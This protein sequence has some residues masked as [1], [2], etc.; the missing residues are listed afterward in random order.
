MVRIDCKSVSKRFYWNTGRQLL[1]TRAL[2]FFRRKHKEE[3][4]F[5]ALRDVSFRVGSGESI[6]LVGRN[7]AGKSTLLGIIAGLAVPDAG[8]ICVN[9]RVA[10]LL[11]L[12]S[13]FHPDLTGAE[14]LMLNAA[15]LG[16]TGKEARERAEA[17]IDFADI[18]EFLD[19]PIR[20]YSSGM[21]VRLAFSI[22][23]NLDPDI[24]IVD[25]VLAV[26]DQNFQAKCLKKIMEF[27]QS[28]KTI[29]AVSHA[30]S[31]LLQLCDRA[32]WLDG[33][34]VIADG[35]IREVLAA[36]EGHVPAS[37][38]SGASA[39]SEQPDA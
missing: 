24:L 34:C 16:F 30:P 19:Q 10:A 35:E 31:L 13:G 37:E 20:T 15:L 4:F 22:A 33:G 36:Y 8:E 21:V 17:I 27:R 29:V 25:E 9:G 7:G 5:Y 28:G 6:A 18:G 1:R 2:A 3:K 23:V 38:H 26:G 39:V 12:G 11:E 14:N 32:V